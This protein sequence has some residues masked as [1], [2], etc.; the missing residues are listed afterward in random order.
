MVEDINDNQSVLR[1]FTMNQQW[2]KKT[3]TLF[4]GKQLTLLVQNLLF[5]DN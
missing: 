3:T 5:K 2:L 4:Q 1:F